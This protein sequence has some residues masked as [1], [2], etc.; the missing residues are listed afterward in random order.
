MKAGCHCLGPD[1]PGGWASHIARLASSRTLRLAHWG[2]VALAASMAFTACRAERTET[3]PVP[4]P[5]VTEAKG[6]AQEQV[7]DL[8]TLTEEYDRLQREIGAKSQELDQ[9][10][11]KYQQRGGVLPA[12][13]N[14]PILGDFSPEQRQLLVERMRQEK[15]SMKSLLQTI[16]DQS[17]QIEDLRLKAAEERRSL[18]EFVEA[19]DGD[20][21]SHLVREYLTKHQQQ[22]S[23]KRRLETRHIV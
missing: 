6:D 11:R 20:R 3:A 2:A 8:T 14:D 17:Q 16:L 4:G 10:T 1:L 21:H 12:T 23:L 18:P 15:G 9:V 19:K 22:Q 13:S 7:E 5:E